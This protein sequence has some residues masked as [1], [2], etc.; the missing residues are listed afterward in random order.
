MV[1]CRAGL[2]TLMITGDYHHTALAVAKQAGMLSAESEVVIVDTSRQLQISTQLSGVKQAAAGFHTSQVASAP[3]VSPELPSPISLLPPD[4]RPAFLGP[5]LSIRSSDLSSLRARLVNLERITDEES[6]EPGLRFVSG[7]NN[8]ELEQGQ[9]LASLAE[10]HARCAVTGAAFE[11][12]LQ[13]QNETT[14]SVVMHSAAVFARMQPHQK[15]QV[16]DL[17][18]C[19]GLHQM[20]SNGSRFIPVTTSPHMLL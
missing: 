3:P 8:Q 1:V 12:L 13:Q 17:L 11:H 19:R 20:T 7:G 16:M 2:K 15:G 5:P 14:L 6:P 4:K 10:G 9:A 18:T